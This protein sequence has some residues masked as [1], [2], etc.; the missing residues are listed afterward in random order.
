MKSSKSLRVAL[1]LAL[2]LTATAAFAKNDALSLVP[3]DAVTV[4]VVHLDQLRTSP[5]ASTLFQHADKMTA[6][7]E[8]DKFLTDAGLDPAK[9]VDLLI[10][11]TSPVTRLGREAEVLVVA[12]GRF[13]VDRLSKALADRGAVK[14][15]ASNVAYFVTPEEKGDKKGA[16]AF[17]SGG[18]AI[19]GTE[20]AVVEALATRA[21]GGSGFAAASLL[22][23]DAARIEP[24]ATAWAVIDVTRAQRLAGGARLPQGKGQAG[25]ALA[26]AA[27]SLSTV[28]LWATD[29]GDSLRLGGFGLSSD[30]ETLGLL[31]DTVRGAL[32]AM[33]LAVKDKAPEMVSVLR[34]FDVSRT[35]DSITISGTIPA[36][37]LRKVMA[38]HRASN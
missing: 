29:S 38:K 23:Q 24:N 34:K 32:S 6:N 30:E 37:E 14:K 20:D 4:G 21:K 25:D 5:L 9:D 18:L 11:A 1:T 33:R 35:S 17:V 28:A 16:V 15:S 26:A 36:S 27:K 10:V 19:L 3:A 12:E 13:N 22:G 31:E 7:G 2:T 8:G